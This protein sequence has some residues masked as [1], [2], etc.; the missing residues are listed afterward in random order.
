MSDANFV[1]VGI[2]DDLDKGPACK[3]CPAIV[4]QEICV[5]ADVKITPKVKVGRVTTFCD[6]PFIGK[7]AAISCS[8]DACEF[9]VSRNL[10]VQIPLLFSAETTV[11]PAGHICG[12]P[13]FEPC[14]FCD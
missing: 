5:Q 12:T 10:C 6:E 8:K 14:K 9:T 2:F 4:S 1:P 7:C 3:E 11:H 13:E